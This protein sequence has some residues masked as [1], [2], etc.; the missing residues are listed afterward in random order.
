MKIISIS[1]NGVVTAVANAVTTQ[2]NNKFYV[3]SHG[4]EGRGRWE[5]R[6]PLAVKDFPPNDKQLILT[7]DYKLIN[8]KKKDKRDNSLYLIVKGDND[9]K[10]LVLLSLSPGYRGGASYKV[11]GKATVI[12]EGYEAQGIA[13]R[14]GESPC[15]IILVEGPCN[16]SW[17]RSGRLYGGG[18]DFIASFDGDKWSVET[19]SKCMLE[20]AAMNYK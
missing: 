14:M 4:E 3:L 11:N 16:L 9:G 17:S 6:I 19:D 13:G 10:Y 15:P 7:E 8:L 2:N 18:S 20:E 12:G 1:K 5:I